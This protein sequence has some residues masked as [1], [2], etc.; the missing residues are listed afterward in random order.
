VG[1]VSAHP[2]NA[3]L[4]TLLAQ[5]DALVFRLDRGDCPPS[6]E[7]ERLAAEASHQGP[8]LSTAERIRLAAAVGRVGAALENS[9]A[10]I[11]ERLVATNI[12]RRASRAYAGGAP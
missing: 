5:L 6:E 10:R 4:D 3:V 1:L 9:S 2:A 12:G 7:M 8:S 11:R